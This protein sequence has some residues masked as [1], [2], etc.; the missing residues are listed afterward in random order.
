[1]TE[2]ISAYLLKRGPQLTSEILRHLEKSGLSPELARQRLKRRP[3]SVKSLSGIT[4]PKN[5]RFYFHETQFGTHRYWDALYHALA[6]GSP[7]YGPAVAAMI[8]KGG[9]VPKE[10]FPIISGAPLKQKKKTGSDAVLSRLKAVGVLTEFT[11][12]ETPVLC[13]HHNTGFSVDHDG[14][15]AQL[16]VQRILLDA[17]AD[18]ARKLNMA[19]YNKVAIRERGQLRYTCLRFGRPQLHVSDGALR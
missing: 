10:Y 17:V 11:M 15:A 13:F 6:E 3:S 8:A 16:T 12:G 18:W 5:A 7:V 4:F 14:L 1:M 2:N 19:S 9:I